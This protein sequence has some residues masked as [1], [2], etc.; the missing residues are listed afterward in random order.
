MRSGRDGTSGIKGSRGKRCDGE[1]PDVLNVAGSQ[2]YCLDMSIL[3]SC[4]E[5]ETYAHSTSIVRSI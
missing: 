4:P 3:L 1:V 5:K 2:T